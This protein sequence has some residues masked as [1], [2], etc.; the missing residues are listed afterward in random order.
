LVST[1][2]H[3]TVR[4]LVVSAA[5]VVFAIA[6]VHRFVWLGGPFFEA[7]H[8]IQDHVW[9][10]PF[11]SRDAILLSSIAAKVLPRGVT[12]TVLQPSLAPNYDNTHFLTAVGL[13]PHQRV[14]APSEPA[15]FVLALREPFDD[16]RYE[17]LEEYAE[18]RIYK[19]R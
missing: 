2:T 1:P 3:E 12:V 6:L 5:A 19:R 7:P 15:D 18:G 8:T 16:A 4:R 9:P 13:M 17:L 11:A 14:V 10:E